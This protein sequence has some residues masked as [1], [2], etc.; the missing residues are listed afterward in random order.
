MRVDPAGKNRNDW[1]VAVS[2]LAPGS[3]N[4]AKEQEFFDGAKQR[5]I[6]IGG[7]AVAEDARFDA[8]RMA[9]V[10]D[11]HDDDGKKEIQWGAPGTPDHPE[12]VSGVTYTEKP[13]DII[14][15]RSSNGTIS[16][17]WK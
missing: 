7:D 9:L 13:F 6:A 5:V 1:G 17:D 12:K 4:L 11:N 8:C 10:V 16:K 2:V 3:A 14:V 15:E